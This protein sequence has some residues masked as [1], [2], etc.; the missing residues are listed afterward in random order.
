MSP[1]YIYPPT[2]HSRS[3]MHL[4]PNLTK[5]QTHRGENIAE[6]AKPLFLLLLRP[7]ISRSLIS[8]RSSLPAV[9]SPSAADRKAGEEVGPENGEGKS[10]PRA[11]SKG[12]DGGGERRGRTG[13]E[14]KAVEQ[15][16]K[17]SGRGRNRLP[18]PE[19]NA[20]LPA[21]KH[22]G[23]WANLEEEEFVFIPSLCRRRYIGRQIWRIH[24]SRIAYFGSWPA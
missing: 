21:A 8:N 24:S 19:S 23:Q 6:M 10:E 22:A 7:L 17:E 14:E 18:R 2:S 12:E 13:T 16:K 20:F 1:Y 9:N 4:A 11:G 3:V 5:T 15:G